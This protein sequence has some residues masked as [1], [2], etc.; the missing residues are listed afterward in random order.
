[1][2]KPVDS[3]S[4]SETETAIL[5][6]A[7]QNPEATNADIAE[8]TGARVA[9]VRDVREEH[10]DNVEL[11]D[12]YDE[13]AATGGVD[14]DG[15]L[16][17]AQESILEYAADNPDAT[18]ADIADATGARVTLVRDTLAEHGDS[19][20]STGS[21][22]GD[23]GSD[24]TAAA[25][26]ESSDTQ[27]AIL[28]YADE[29]PD[30]TNAE[31]ADE[32]GARVT[33]VRDTLAEHGSGSSSSSSSGSSGGSSTGSDSDLQSEI[34]DYADENPEATNAEIADAVGARVTLVRDTLA[35][36]DYSSEIET[37]SGGE[38]PAGVSASM[39][40]ET[41]QAILELAQEDDELTNADIAEKTGT[42]VSVVRDTR[43]KHEPGKSADYGGEGTIQEDD[44]DDEEETA[45]ETD[46]SREWTP[47]DP[48]EL[49][50]EILETALQ[51]EELTNAEIATETGARLTLVRDTLTDYDDLTLDD[52]EDGVSSSYEPEE[53]SGRG[54]LSDTEQA[55]LDAA[56]E[57]PEATNAEIAEQVG[58]RVTLVR[59]TREN[60]SDLGSGSS[61]GDAESSAADAG[62][63]GSDD[64]L[65]SGRLIALAVIVLVLIIA[66]VLLGGS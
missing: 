31:I 66:V 35:D 17:A 52:L 51:N 11:P 9:L 5:T 12:D 42:T 29:N 33:L 58:A 13:S 44:E 7:L 23:S 28:D 19:V 57:D 39:L 32:V 16:S 30:A 43:V 49:Q 14:A 40:N 46:E 47:G 56:D 26:K 2:K 62:A 15:D 8:E 38:L 34:V 6:A 59:D 60:Y 63:A 50:E 18:N 25:S 4:F 24:S 27:Q 21:S 41:E 65:S 1:M 53:P 22:G 54:D 3:A 37:A 20:E 45:D 48:T 61:G 55:I 64:G 36:N 10:E